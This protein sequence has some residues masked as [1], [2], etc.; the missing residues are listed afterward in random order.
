MPIE[1]QAMILVDKNFN[2]NLE[3]CLLFAAAIKY[4]NSQYCN[5]N[6]L[7]LLQINKDILYHII[8]FIFKLFDRILNKGDTI[9][10][11]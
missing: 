4:E 9:E 8:L 2:K 7:T 11:I 3:K 10:S 5:N 6:I 1:S